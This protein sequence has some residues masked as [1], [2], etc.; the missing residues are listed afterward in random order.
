M[1]V[2]AGKISLK[3]AALH[4]PSLNADVLMS[5]KATGNAADIFSSQAFVDLIKQARKD[6]DYIVIDTPPV[7]AVPDARIIGKQV[8]TTLY[9]VRWDHTTHRQVAQGI[10]EL[11]QVNVPIAGLVL[12]QID[13]KGLKRYGY[14]DLVN[15]YSGYHNN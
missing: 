12:G 15:A 14:G 4:E 6:Y 13:R 7:L 3:E 9:T 8:D 10:K 2:L 11:E 1:A 5:E